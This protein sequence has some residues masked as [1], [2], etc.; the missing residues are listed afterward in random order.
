VLLDKLTS[1]QKIIIETTNNYI[2]LKIID[3][4]SFISGYIDQV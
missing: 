4:P 1:I 3:N 2:R